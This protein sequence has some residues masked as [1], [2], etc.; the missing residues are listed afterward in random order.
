MLIYEVH[1][2]NPDKKMKRFPDPDIRISDLSEPSL[3]LLNID[4][5]NSVDKLLKIYTSFIEPP[6][7]NYIRS[8]INLLM[9][10]GLIENRV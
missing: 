1:D 7:E 10:L 3:R 4:K 2:H 5:I 6:R 9:Q 8:A